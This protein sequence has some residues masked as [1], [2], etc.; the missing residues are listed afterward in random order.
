MTITN[1]YDS[2]QEIRHTAF[3]DQENGTPD[4]DNDYRK[5]Y[6]EYLD[7]RYGYYTD[8]ENE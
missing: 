3:P 6:L 4:E 5:E 2:L 8:P 1:A 7:E